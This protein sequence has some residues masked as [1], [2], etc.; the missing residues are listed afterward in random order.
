M[1]E[2]LL[3]GEVC[4]QANCTPRTV[5]HYENEKIITPVAITP[6]GHKLYDTD[7]VAIIR[8]VQ[9][10]KRLGYSLRDIR[11]IISLTRSRNTGQRRL[12]LRLRSMLSEC[13]AGIDSELGLLSASREKIAGLLEH[14]ETCESCTAED[15]NACGKLK[16]LRT[17]GLLEV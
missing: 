14:T 1:Q 10:L 11:K 13:L 16:N 12:T 15:C 7:T 3:I 9:L 2:T 4:R 17:L 8:T 5:R 6:G